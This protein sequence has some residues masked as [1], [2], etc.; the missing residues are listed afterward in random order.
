MSSKFYTEKSFLFWLLF[1]YRLF[2]T[3]CFSYYYLMARL[4]D[5]PSSGSSP[6]ITYPNVRGEDNKVMGNKPQ[7]SQIAPNMNDPAPKTWLQ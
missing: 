5:T 7:M 6:L 4:R 2:P 1:P 3:A